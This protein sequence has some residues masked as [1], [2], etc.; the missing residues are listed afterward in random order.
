[1]ADAAVLHG[2]VDIIDTEGTRVELIG[3]KAIAGGQ[4]SPGS[5]GTHG[6]FL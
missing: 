4:G 6:N 1:M 2:D 3:L 5:D